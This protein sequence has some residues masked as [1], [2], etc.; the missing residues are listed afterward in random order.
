M[1]SLAS[2]RRPA[3]ASPG[4]PATTP[5]KKWKNR[6]MGKKKNFQPETPKESDNG[7]GR[8]LSASRKQRKKGGIMRKLR[9]KKDYETDA[10]SFNHTD[11]SPSNPQSPLSERSIHSV[12][13]SF[14]AVRM[15]NRTMYATVCFP[16][17][18][19]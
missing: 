11:S 6:L 2:P 18:I 5:T 12:E 19:L 9:G 1:A 4:R 7:V 14:S 17:C 8:S 10:T 3:T 13:V 16:D 15:E